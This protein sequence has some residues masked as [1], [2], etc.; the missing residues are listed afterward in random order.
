M[1]N[2]LKGSDLARAMLKRGDKNFWCAVAD[3]SDEQAISDQVGNDFTVHIVSFEDG[4]FYCSGGM[5]WSYAVPV[6]LIE[7]IEYIGSAS[8]NK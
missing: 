4:S 5:P 7:I 3:E 8:N 6:K 1:N 2:K